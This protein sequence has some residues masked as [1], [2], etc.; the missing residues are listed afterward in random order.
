MA[1]WPTPANP[2]LWQAAASSD[3]AAFTRPVHLLT[4]EGQWL[5]QPVLEAKFIEALRQSRD[6]RAFLDFARFYSANVDESSDG[7]IITL[8]DLRFNLR[9]RAE[10]DHDLNVKAA[11]TRWF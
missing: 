7:Y 3:T 9:L 5:E 4:H 1:A 11:E 6:G 8:R 2:T 10:L